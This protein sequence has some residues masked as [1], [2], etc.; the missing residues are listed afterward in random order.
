MR[1]NNKRFPALN[2]IKGKISQNGRKG[3][4]RHYHYRSDPKLGPGIVS[5]GIIPFNWHACTTIIFLSW[6][7]KIKEAVNHPRYG[8]VHKCKYS[9]ILSC[10]N[11]WIILIFLDD[12][13][14]E[15]DY[16]HIN[17]TI[18]DGNV[19][20]NYLIIME[21]K[22]CAIDADDFSCHS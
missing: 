16:E 8:R 18:I 11:N 13:R 17:W 2:G 14:Y 9:Q 21:R 20:N 3:I 10:R 22:Y 6:D 19:M 1:Q 5:V 4:L 7:S 12:V 15:E